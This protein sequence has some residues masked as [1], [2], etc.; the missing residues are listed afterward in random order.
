MASFGIICEGVSENKMISHLI[1]R[2]LGD[3]DV[4]AVQPRISATGKQDNYGGWQQVLEHCNVEQLNN[5]FTTNDYLVIQIDTDVC[6]EYGVNKKDQNNNQI[7]DK[8]IY[9]KVA[10]RLKNK[11]TKE[12]YDKYSNKIIFAI[13]INEIECWLLPLYYDD[14]RRCATDSCIK[15][16]NRKL[17]KQNLGI[18]DTDKNCPQAQK[19]YGEIFKLMKK[20]STIQEISQYNYGFQK[21]V[22]QLDN[23]K[24]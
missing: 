13:C 11:I 5:V 18:P 15:K 4:N 21:F 1:R 10:D 17:Q 16:L 24:I 12:I 3:V 19:A 14:N 6:D 7:S 22:E 20:K 9:E 8:L 2:Y 23:I